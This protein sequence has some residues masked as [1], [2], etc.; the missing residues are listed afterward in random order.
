M[1][2][3]KI[4]SLL[5]GTALLAACGGEPKPR[6]VAELLEDPIALEAAVVRCAQNR[7]ETRYEAECVNA[8]QAVSILEARE[9]RERAAAFEQESQRKREALR[10]TQAAAA[11][12]RRR[13]AEAEQRRREAEYV[14]QF[15]ETLPADAGDAGQL[16][17]P[18]DEADAEMPAGETTSGVPAAR[19]DSGS[20]P[21]EGEEAAD[22][23]EEESSSDLEAVRE[24]LR[25]R[26]EETGG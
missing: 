14:A 22:A 18:V 9:D 6:S 25:R 12:A 10:R 15:D 21:E 13:A 8:R 2:T 4:V 7:S 23:A 19:I 24:E 11:E 20:E 3:H 1:I 16:E 26:N 5:C 17:M